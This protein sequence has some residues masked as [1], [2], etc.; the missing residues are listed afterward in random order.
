MTTLSISDFDYDADFASIHYYVA[1]SP[2]SM[3][4]PTTIGSGYISY[5][6]RLVITD[7]TFIA[8]DPY[9]ADV[10][11]EIVQRVFTYQQWRD[12]CEDI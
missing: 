7:D 9:I 5:A 8:S 3:A 4:I 6:D 12:A 11:D 10:H 2:R 1:T